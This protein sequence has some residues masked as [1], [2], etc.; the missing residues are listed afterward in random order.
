MAPAAS[1]S[2]NAPIYSV[3]YEGN[4]YAGHLVKTLSKGTY[5]TS[6]DDVAAY[7][8]AFGEMPANYMCA[9]GDDSS[10]YQATKNKAYVAY[11]TSARLW[12][13]YHRTSGYMNQVPVYNTYGDGSNKATYFEIDIST[14]WSS[15]SGNRG[16]E[17]L[18]AMPYG[19]T[20][21]GDVPV[22]FHTTDHYDT[23]TEYLN[24][25]SGWGTSFSGRSDYSMPATVSYNIA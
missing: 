20:E 25:S 4:H 1:S 5:Y 13:T 3:S 16:A 11:G 6:Y 10:G 24:Y 12:F 19:L 8:Q 17:R 7:W 18:M 21:Y 22:I 15:Y 14:N 2:S 9:D 23:F